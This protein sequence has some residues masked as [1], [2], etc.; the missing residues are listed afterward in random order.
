MKYSDNKKILQS[1]YDQNGLLSRLEKDSVYLEE[2]FNDIY[3]I[4]LDNFNQIE[5]VNYLMLA[6]APLWG[7]AKKYIY[8]QD[9]NNSQFFYRSD[10]EEVLNKP[11]AD[12]KEFIQVCNEI[13]LLIVDISPFPLNSKDT[14]I[15]YRKSENGSKKL[16]KNQYKQLVNLTVPT[17]FEKKIKLV[18]DKRPANIKTFFR[19]ARVKNSFESIVSRVLIDNKIIKTQNDIG[20]ISKKGGGIDKT[21]LKQIIE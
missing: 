11:I 8:N 13:G 3:R 16:N 2:A 5:S 7:K 12:K 21:K 19:Y 1:F 14:K 10:L 4:W 6:E 17:F 20:D 18:A 15:N 9:I